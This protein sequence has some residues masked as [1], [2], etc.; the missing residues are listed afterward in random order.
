MRIR[1]TM[2][3]N[4]ITIAPDDSIKEAY[5]IMKE[6]DFRHIPV[7]EGTSLLGILSER[8]ILMHSSY[9]EK[10]LLVPE[11][12]AYEVMTTDVITCSPK[13][14]VADAAAA[15]VDHKI[16]CLPVIENKEIVGLVTS[17][18]L[19]DIL[20]QWKSGFERH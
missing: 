15:M 1:S 2:T 13:S 4:V 6:F 17:T 9:E 11:I 20:C 16:G 18:D 8:D 12:P 14:T 10:K 7:V 19:L 3:L 5:E